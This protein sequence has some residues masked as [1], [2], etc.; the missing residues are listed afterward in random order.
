[1]KSMDVLEPWP[2]APLARSATARAQNERCRRNAYARANQLSGFLCV[3]NLPLAAC[4]DVGH[5]DRS[6]RR[7]R[8]AEGGGLLNRYRLVKAYRGFESLRL[9]QPLYLRHLDI[10]APRQTCGAQ[11]LS[12]V[13]AGR[14]DGNRFCRYKTRQSL[15]LLRSSRMASV[16]SSGPPPGASASRWRRRR[17]GIRVS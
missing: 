6:R 11:C 7:G 8:V 10:K 3:L 9:R 2:S 4:R 5:T 16:A 13:A 14:A 15:F 17:G 1:M 12:A